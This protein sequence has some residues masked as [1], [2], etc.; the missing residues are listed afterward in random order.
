[1]ELFRDVV[2][3]ALNIIVIIICMAMVTTLCE[4]GVD[5]T[6]WNAM[7]LEPVSERGIFEFP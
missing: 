3:G 6:L 7:F 2:S 5:R 4:G 1:M